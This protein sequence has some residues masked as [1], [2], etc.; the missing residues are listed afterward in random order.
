MF[1]HLLSDYKNNIS[2]DDMTHYDEI[3]KL[4]DLKH[5]SK[6]AN[7]ENFFEESKNNFKNRHFHHHVFNKDS[8][9]KMLN[10]VGFNVQQYYE[11]KDDLITVGQLNN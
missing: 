7:Y 6:D 4:H 3:I 9:F 5:Y 2:E 8:I 1:D 10:F 11:H